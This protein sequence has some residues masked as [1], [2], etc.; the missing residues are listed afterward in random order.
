LALLLVIYNYTHYV[1]ASATA[2]I[3]AMYPAFLGVAIAVGA[4]PL[5]AALSFAFFSSLFAA[6]THYGTGSAVVIYG[7][8]YVSQT[9][10][11]RIGF[12]LSLAHLPLW[13]GIGFGWWKLLGLW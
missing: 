9:R 3:T 5:L 4:P 11:W 12:A 7:A 2:H 6:L 8:G 1:F 10:W 13:L